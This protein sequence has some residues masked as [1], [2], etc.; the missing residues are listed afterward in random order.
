MTGAHQG[1]A[2]QAR[3][4]FGK[5][6]VAVSRRTDLS[7]GAKVVYAVLRMFQNA[8]SGQCDPTQQ[9]LAVSTGISIRMVSRHI[10][11]LRA[12]GILFTTRGRHGLIYGLQDL[13]DRAPHNGHNVESE[14]SEIR[15]IVDEDTTDSGS[16]K[17]QIVESNGQIRHIVE[18][19]TPDSGSVI[20]DEKKRQERSTHP[21]IPGSDPTPNAVALVGAWDQR[22]P[23]T[24]SGTDAAM[25]HN[26]VAQ[27]I[28]DHGYTGE[29]FH[30]VMDYLETSGDIRWWPRP[31][32]LLRHT[33]R[34][35]GPLAIATIEMRMAARKTRG[36]NRPTQRDRTRTRQ[37]HRPRT[38]RTG[39]AG[40]D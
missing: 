1:P 23:R 34:G 18:S 31:Y 16:E 3:T 21:R 17:R 6:D 29:R 36:A 19:D 38:H 33:D 10:N 12:A 30:A 7:A 14:G 4:S 20:K 8:S 28:R 15:Q 32:R 9:T 26:A 24:R 39:T 11:E 5:L 22:F 25:D 27:L 37:T 2:S 35:N 40:C 13:P